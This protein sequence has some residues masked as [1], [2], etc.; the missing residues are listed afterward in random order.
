MES[1][2]L[3]GKSSRVGQWERSL[4]RVKER[5]E[6]AKAG[7]IVLRQ[8]IQGYNRGGV[9]KGGDEIVLVEVCNISSWLYWIIQEDSVLDLLRNG[10]LR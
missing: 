1:K 3:Q 10:M 9:P 5:G 8:R 2:G 4:S 7:R 6:Q